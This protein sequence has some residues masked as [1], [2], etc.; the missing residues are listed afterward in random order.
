MSDLDD[1]KIPAAVGDTQAGSAASKSVTLIAK[2]GKERL[3][4]EHL[5]SDTSIGEVKAMIYDRTGVLPKRQKLIGL[6]I[7]GRKASGL[8]DNDMLS[9]LKTKTS[10]K[11]VDSATGCILHQFMLMGTP[12]ENIFVDPSDRGDLPDVIDDFELD[13]NAGSDQWVQHVANGQNLKK[14]TES[15]LIHVMNPPRENKLLLVLDLDHTLLDFSSKTLARDTSTNQVGDGVAATMKRPYM[16]AFL[17]SAYK[18]YDMVVWSQTSWY[19]LETKLTELGMLTHPQYKF[20]FVLDKTSMFAIT[21][22]RRG[23]GETYKH[24]VKPMQIIWTK[25]PRWGSHNSVHL[26]DLSRNFALNLGSGLKVDAY[27]RKKKAAKRDT[28]LLGMTHYLKE[29]SDS[30]ANF[31]DVD[32]AAWQD[33]VARRRPLAKPREEEKK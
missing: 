16:D 18:H 30:E 14:F 1:S 5:R 24:S 8:M 29:L 6:S 32:F 26:D 23:G 9:E 17:A 21:S 11:P 28:V 12:E 19:W 27:Y 2:W 22:A 31:D 25:F 13:F 3:T 20:C 15:T 4:M 10:K 7:L 33:V